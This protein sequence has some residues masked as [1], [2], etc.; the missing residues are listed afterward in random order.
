MLYRLPKHTP[1]L[2]VMLEDLGRPRPAEVAKMLGVHP[3]TVYHWIAKDDAPRP[4]LL[5]LFWVTRWGLQWTD[6]EVY[7]LAQVHMSLAAAYKRRLDAIDGLAAPAHE[8][9]AHKGRPL[10]YVVR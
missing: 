6:A 9:G 8:E 3:R 5:A 4:A 2:S 1:P 10:L 7:N